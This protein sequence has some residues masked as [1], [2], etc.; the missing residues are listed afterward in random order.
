MAEGIVGRGT[1]T[2]RDG[3][4]C[5]AGADVVVHTRTRTRHVRTDDEG[6]FVVTDLA[7]ER[8][9]LSVRYPGYAPGA[10]TVHIAGD[11][12]HVADLGTIDLM[13]SGEAEGDVVDLD[14]QPVAGARVA[15]DEAPAYLPVGPLPLGTVVT[16]RSGHFKLSG[17]P[18]GRVTL[19]AYA[20]DSGRAQANDVEIEQ[21]ERP[22]A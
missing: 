11:A 20:S 16:D 15:R 13:E 12:D 7:P 5:L 8:V 2:G 3:R 10:A 18:E 19:E 9:R 22:K 14:D 21:V 17:L 4:D 6:V 1:V